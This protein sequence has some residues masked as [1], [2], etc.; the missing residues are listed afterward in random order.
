MPPGMAGRG[1]DPNHGSRANGTR[2]KPG[3]LPG[4][5]CR[6]RLPGR[7]LPADTPVFTVPAGLVRILD[8]D[9]T[10]RRGID[11]SGMNGAGRLTFTPCGIPSAPC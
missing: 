9:L 2:A 1:L 7:C 4:T 6:C 8:R 10:A 5:F 11:A 3:A